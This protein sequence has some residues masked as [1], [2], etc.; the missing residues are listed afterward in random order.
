MPGPGP[1]FAPSLGTFSLW[2]MTEK[3][4]ELPGTLSLGF[5]AQLGLWGSWEEAAGGHARR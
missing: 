2:E 4:E 5:E 1:S 3:A